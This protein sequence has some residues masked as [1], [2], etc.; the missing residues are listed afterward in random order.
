MELQSKNSF[1]DNNRSMRICC[2]VGCSNSEKKNPELSFYSFPGRNY[3]VERKQKWIAA[4]RRLS[5]GNKLWQ[6]TANSRICSAHFDGGCKSDDPRKVSYIP[7]IFP[8]KY[9]SKNKYDHA[10]AER[11][12]KRNEQKSREECE[13][14]TFQNSNYDDSTFNL[15]QNDS[16]TLV[17]TFDICIQTDITL[18]IPQNINII[19]LFCS[20]D[21]NDKSTQTDIQLTSYRT[22][23]EKVVVEDQEIQEE[24]SKLNKNYKS[25]ACGSDLEMRD[26]FTGFAGITSEQDL[27]ILTGIKF[28]VF[29]HLLKFIIPGKDGQPQFFRTLSTED[30]LLLFL[31]KLKLGISFSA[32]GLLF[33]VSRQTVSNIFFSILETVYKNVKKWIF[34]PSKEAVKQTMPDTFVNYPDCRVIIDCTEVYTDTP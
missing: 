28:D 29:N 23:K 9:R 4:V 25:V 17:E 15:T 1:V 10:R 13:I 22:I 31:M 34:W 2:V 27:K 20:S 14:I 19:H 12:Q 32:I 33:G 3:E 21:G 8:E 7:T 26:Y 18:D 11:L 30:R 24:I 5:E 6:P 16:S